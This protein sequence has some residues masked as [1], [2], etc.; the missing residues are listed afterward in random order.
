MTDRG[1]IVVTLTGTPVA[2]ARARF[3]RATGHAF[4]PAK[5]RQYQSALRLA[6]QRS[7]NGR[8][9]LECALSVVV[10]AHFPIPTSWS[11]RRRELAL[12][13]QLMPMVKPDLDNLLKQLDSFN[14]VIWVDD[15]QVV[16]AL[17]RKR[18]SDRPMLHVEISEVAR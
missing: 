5:T 7:M 11:R 17:V 3:V 14:Q 9:P 16:T 18:Y 15:R 13:G 4:T 1:R 12:A 8:T 2:V 10:D 6:A